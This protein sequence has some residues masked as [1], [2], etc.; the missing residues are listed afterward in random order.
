MHTSGFEPPT[1]GLG[2]PPACSRV[3]DESDVLEHAVLEHAP[4]AEVSQAEHDSMFCEISV[5][6]AMQT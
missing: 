1:R 4:V 5:P 3:G 6:G 2:S